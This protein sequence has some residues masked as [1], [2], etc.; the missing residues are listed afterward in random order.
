MTGAL[1][2][3]A[4]VAGDLAALRLENERI[5]VTITPARG[6]D[7][8]DLLDRDRDLQVLW[9]SPAWG[10]SPMRWPAAEV[11][12]FFD[13]YPG[14]MQEMFP[15]GGP[16]CVYEGAELGFHGEA[17]KVPWT[18]EIG[19]REGRIEI[20]CSTRLARLPFTLRKTF[21]L[22][23][24]D[25][26]VRI[27][28]EITNEGRRELRYMW[29]FHPAFGGP[30]LGER[31]VVHCPAARLRVHGERFGANQQL[32]PG[33]VHG[34]PVA[35]GA[36]RSILLADSDSGADLW[37]LDQLA[38]GWYV[39]ENPE[40]DVLVTMTWDVD[41]FPYVWLWQQCHDDDGA[42]WFGAQHMVAVEPW[43]SYS[44]SGLAAAIEN[45]SAPS[46]APGETHEAS[47]TLGVAARAGAGG[48]P[49]GVTPRGEV[50]FA[51][52]AG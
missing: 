17:C 38:D 7:V 20:R 32:P 11:G 23:R 42:P 48:A 21:S 25:S 44:G 22:G 4:T 27:D 28:A 8:L 5:A 14:G 24:D 34:W 30:V 52:G 45:G 9:H 40:N 50:S 36:D 33:G 46:I 6:A 13:H 49:V 41:R 12:D 37:Y 47:L 19:E 10:R 39:I 2:A 16:S 51:E 43:T 29:G 15:N 26:A 31:T 1:R 35:D 3:G 18:H